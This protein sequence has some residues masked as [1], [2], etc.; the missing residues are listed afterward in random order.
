M[1]LFM[2]ENIGTFWTVVS[3][4]ITVG[5]GI[6]GYRFYK[7][8]LEDKQTSK[9]KTLEAHQQATESMAQQVLN[10]SEMHKQQGERILRLEEE[11][12]RL[13][14]RLLEAIKA[15]VQAEAKVKL[16]QSKLQYLEKLLNNYTDVNECCKVIKFSEGSDDSEE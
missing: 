7:V 1:D 12:K 11:T 8:Y 10:F 14:E 2:L 3:Y 15:H 13:N 9:A 16:L 5:I 6:V 4:I